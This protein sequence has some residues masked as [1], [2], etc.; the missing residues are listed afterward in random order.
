MTEYRLEE[1]AVIH[2]GG[3][4]RLSGNDFVEDGVPAYGAGGQN[5]MVA[6]AEYDREAIVLSSIGA[7]CGKCFHVRGQ[8]TSLA[9]TQV[10]LPDE[11]RVDSRFLWYQLNDEARWPRSGSAQ[12][13]IKPSDVKAHRIW[14]PTLDSQ[15]GI[16]AILDRVVHLREKRRRV[17]VHLEELTRS[18]F[19]DT[20]GQPMIAQGTW[21]RVMLGDL[22]R[23]IRGASPRPAGDPRYFGGQIPWLKIADITAT[24]GRV[25]TKIKEGVTE[26]GRG[27]SVLLPPQT[28][29]LTNSATV[30]I[31]K[32]IGPETCIHDGFLAFLDL[33]PRV[34]QT[35]LYAA[36]LVSRE[37]LVALAPEGTQK[38]LNG[39][40][41]KAVEISLPPIELQR[42]FVSRLA[43]MESMRVSALL[44]AEQI[45]D[46]SDALQDAAFNGVLSSE[47]K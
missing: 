8:W 9:N 22:A 2:G 19:L 40:I 44:G 29:V 25:V 12:P 33:D 13:F 16:A 27:K 18:V 46:L 23:I 30:G 38:N 6:T 15:R 36:L 42:G 4:L 37:R 3:R 32:I 17:L 39:P 41:V 24:P 20:F 1:V 14:L 21:P 5:G 26:A 35:W 31:P 45:D 43:A 11:S 10:I 47:I 28:L 7:R 34:D